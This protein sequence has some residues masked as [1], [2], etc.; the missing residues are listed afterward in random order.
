[1]NKIEKI[2][3]KNMATKITRSERPVN[4]EHRYHSAYNTLCHLLDDEQDIY[5]KQCRFFNCKLIK[6]GEK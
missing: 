6:N 3:E 1:M 2:E 4:C 5:N